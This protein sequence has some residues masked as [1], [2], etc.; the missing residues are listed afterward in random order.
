MN[1]LLIVTVLIIV[2]LSSCQT[3]N[4]TINTIDFDKNGTIEIP[5]IGLQKTK[6]SRAKILT[7]NNNTYLVFSDRNTQLIYVYSW[8]G[9]EF[10]LFDTIN[11]ILPYKKGFKNLNEFTLKNLDTIIISYTSSYFNYLHDSTTFMTN[12]QK[13]FILEGNFEAAPVL[14]N[15]K[16]SYN[17]YD[18]DL[19][20]KKNSNFVSNS[21]DFPIFYHEKFKGIITPIKD[22]TNY[23]NYCR[24]IDTNYRY[25]AGIL[26]FDGRPFNPL[27]NI[28]Y[29][30]T[31]TGVYYPINFKYIR[32]DYNTRN[33]D[34]VFGFG[35]NNV[36]TILDTNLNIKRIKVDSY[37]LDTIYPYNFFY[38]EFT[39]YSRGEFLKII[40]DY[41]YDCYY[42]IIRVGNN[43]KDFNAEIKP[44]KYQSIKETYIIQKINNKFKL[45]SEGI[46]P[47]EY[48]ND[49][50]SILPFKNYLLFQ[51]PVKSL[52]KG[53]IIFDKIILREKKSNV[54]SF[55]N[56]V[57]NL[58]E[59][60]KKEFLGKSYNDYV[61]TITN[62]KKSTI[63][64]NMDEAC[65]SCIEYFFQYL[66]INMD[67]I[68]YNKL[69]IILI[70]ANKKYLMEVL[71]RDSLP[72]GIYVDD[73]GISKRYVGN[74]R[75]AVKID[76]VNDSSYIKQF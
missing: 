29:P 75:N 31:D 32:G 45:I 28:F 36:F 49:F 74:I 26:Y 16:M 37:I 19:I 38:D 55:K 4:Q 20:K 72:K 21:G 47:E 57:F 1:N 73:L 6:A 2:L 44:Q 27:K 46:V 7:F 23:T 71:N 56:E 53:R 54:I 76:F 42:R 25:S 34:V 35:N 67:K 18:L 51:N 9:M 66:K 69:S 12:K 61:Y 30:C 41:N 62:H 39:D 15:N 40:Y 10:N 65:R 22:L 24:N 50:M 60:K 64:Y 17:N 5:I 68:D 63:V 52:E 11:Y 14:T 48:N 59:N 13:D 3:N 43:V 8:N 33:H 70:T 58:I